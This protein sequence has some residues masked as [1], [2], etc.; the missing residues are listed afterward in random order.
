MSSIAT[1]LVLLALVVASVAGC[2]VSPRTLE[3]IAFQEAERK[4]LT[5]AG[6]PQYNWD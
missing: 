3:I 4:R 1:K 6:F 5:A 2:A